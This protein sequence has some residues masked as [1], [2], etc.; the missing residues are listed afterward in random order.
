MN[1]NPPIYLCNP[2]LR[3][4]LLIA[5]RERRWGERQTQSGSVVSCMCPTW[6]PRDQT[7][8]LLVYGM[9]LQ[10]TEPHGQG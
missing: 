4:Y 9:M 3:L 6:G 8:N 2:H 7:C 5:E 10:R 1:L